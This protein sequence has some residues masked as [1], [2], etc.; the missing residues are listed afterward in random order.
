MVTIPTHLPTA[1]LVVGNMHCPS[2]VESITNLLAALPSV[3]NLSVSLLLHR[4]TFAIDTSIGS[5]RVPTS[6]DRVVEQVAHTLK[7]EGGFEVATEGGD[8]EPT[9]AATGG[10]LDRVFGKR[11]ADKASKIAEERRRRHLE[12]CEACQAEEAGERHPSSTFPAPPPDQVLVTTLS[13]E[14]MTCASCTSS[15]SKALEGEPS[16]LSVEVNLLSSS[17]TVRHKASLSADEVAAMVDDVGFEAEVLESR[18]EAP[19]RAEE[20]LIKTTLS[21]EG[22][23]CASCSGAIDRAVRKHPDVTDAAI[24]VLLNKGVFTHRPALTPE[25]LKDIVEDVGYDATIVSSALLERKGVPGSRT[26][27]VGV[28]GMFCGQC[29]IKINNALAA[30]PLLSYTPITLAAPVSTLT[31]IPRDPLT[32]RDILRDLTALAPEFHAEVVRAQS[33]SERSQEIQ[34]REVRLLAAHLAV[35]VLFAIPTF[36]IA[37]VSMVLLKAEHPFRRFWDQ[38]V[39]GGANLGTVVQWPLATAVQFGVGWI[40][41]K[42]AF[43]ALWPHLRALVPAPLR[44]KSMRRLPARP[45]TWRALVSFGSMDLLVTLST[46]VS[47]FASIAMMALDV[48]AGPKS[49]SVG[50]YF[51]SSVFLIMFI[52][53]GR[54]IEA[55]AKSR[56]TDAVA[57]LGNLRPATA[58]LVEEANAEGEKR[59]STDTED[60]GPHEVPVDH[61]EYGDVIL[62]M[63]GSLPPTDGVVVSGTSKFD[64]SSLTG[65]SLPVTKNPGDEVYT[66]TTNQTSAIHVRVTGLAAE[67]MLERIIQAVSDASGRK[68]PLEKAAERLTGVFVPLVVYFALGVLA[69]WMGMVYG[70]RIAPH[71]YH[72]PGGRA[73]FALEFAIAVLVVACPCGIGLAVPCA[74]AVGNGLAAATGILAS[75][76]GEAFTAATAVTTIAF[77]KTGTLTTGQ[78]TVTDEYVPET[79]LGAEVTRALRAVEA[80]STHP[81]AVGLASYLSAQSSAALEVVESTEIAG[82]GLRATVAGERTLELLVGNA[83]LLTENNVDIPPSAEETLAQ[84]STDAKSVVLCA[85]RPA[86]AG[87][88]FVLTAMYALADAPRE[89]TAGVLALLRQRGYR[90]VMLSGDNEVTARAVGRLVG[91]TAEDVHAGVGPQGKAAAI[92]EMQVRRVAPRIALGPLKLGR[93]EVVERV[94][95]VGDGLNDAVALAAADVSAAMGHGSQATLASADFVLLRSDLAALPK[96]L[97]LSCKVRNRQWFN[98]FWAMIFNTVFLPI[99]AGVLFPVG[100]TLSPVW[101]AV[102]MACSSISVVLS[103]LALRWGL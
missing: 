74:N 39:W 67:T 2:C 60:S 22:M 85:A 27:T 1:S 19:E 86:G 16:I 46:T 62:I 76:G 10:L 14:G 34:R 75:G 18:P 84:W 21:I 7:S 17:G 6:V 50:T 77:D 56:T 93:K 82:R 78:S 28:Q 3:K 11:R 8:V 58:L 57:L 36:I 26:V 44:S 80:Q 73:F 35:A 102:L 95:F 15:I 66:G 29:V 43:N 48:K 20:A 99:A 45:L 31:Y 5:S 100:F 41:Y 12:H 92:A 87:N 70:G 25:A 101:S 61:V 59:L 53:L 54:T 90:V 23:T 69:F 55:Y 9:P 49:M 72:G 42:R 79:E 63:P 98:L 96:L 4:V 30:M 91:I 47:Y 64:E 51:D 94:M 38:P 40:F 37:I 65:E 71:H 81:L 88:P 83:A 89:S 52:L 103:S 24:D 97:R 68:A 32:I 33:L 13:I